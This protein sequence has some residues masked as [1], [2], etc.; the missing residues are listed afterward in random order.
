MNTANIELQTETG[1]KIAISAL[2]VPDIAVPLQN[3]MKTVVPQLSYLRGLK[4]AHPVNADDKFE[5]SLLIGADYYWD[6]VGDKIIRGN[7]PTAVS[8]KI[9]YLLSGPVA[10]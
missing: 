4:L 8:S 6:I 2:I 9:G 5:I 10:T 7:G 1:E 3:K